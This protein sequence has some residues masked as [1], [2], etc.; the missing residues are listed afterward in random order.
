MYLKRFLYSE[1]IGVFPDPGH[2]YLLAQKFRKKDNPVPVAA[3]Q[4]SFARRTAIEPT[5]GHL[6]TDH[7]LTCNFYKGI[8]DDNINVMLAAADMNFKR[9]I[10]IWKHHLLYFFFRLRQVRLFR[11]QLKKKFPFINLL[12]F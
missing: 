2:S 1:N 6:K 10:N 8:K 11:L 3:F 4:K 7:R 5:I 9:M 12:T